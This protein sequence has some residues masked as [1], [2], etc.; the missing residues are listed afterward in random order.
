MYEYSLAE[1]GNIVNIPVRKLRYVVDHELIP[2][3]NWGIVDDEPGNP[4]KVD[5]ISGTFI[6]AAA[7]LLESGVKREIVKNALRAADELKPPGRNQLNLPILFDAFGSKKNSSISIGDGMNVRVRV[8]RTDS[9][10]HEIVEPGNKA[11]NSY[12]PIVKITV[13]LAKIRDLI[14]T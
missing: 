11:D 5:E 1:L 7:M 3:R 9:G 2:D 12:E 13:S 6:V 8:G 4:R 14:P 10:W